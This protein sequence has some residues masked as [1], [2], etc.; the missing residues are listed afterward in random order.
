MP[1]DEDRRRKLVRI[2]KRAK[3][4]GDTEVYEWAKSEYEKSA[5]DSPAATPAAPPADVPGQAAPAGRGAGRVGTPPKPPI[6][7]PA[8]ANPVTGDLLLDS[9]DPFEGLSGARQGAFEVPPDRAPDLERAVADSK[10]LP[11]FPVRESYDVIRPHE[12]YLDLALVGLGDAIGSMPF[13]GDPAK[14]GSDEWRRA[15]QIP[16]QLIAGIGADPTINAPL[17]GPD[18]SMQE[19]VRGVMESLGEGWKQNVRA[20]LMSI[21][22]GNLDPARHL[23]SRRTLEKQHKADEGDP[24]TLVQEFITDAVGTGGAGLLDDAVKGAVRRGKAAAR[25]PV[26]EALGILD[27]IP[28]SQRMAVDRA[29][30]AAEEAVEHSLK[31]GTDAADEAASAA[32]RRAREAAEAAETSPHIPRWFDDIERQLRPAEKAPPGPSPEARRA[33]LERE[34]ERLERDLGTMPAAERRAA[35]KKSEKIREQLEEL[36]EAL[37]APGSRRVPQSPHYSPFQ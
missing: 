30:R 3:E 32:V 2:G 22:Q 24:T 19:Y 20:G 23:Y 9:S 7:V 28:A 21:A 12:S 18:S 4:A 15:T 36:P 1:G 33:A 14:G 6:P 35:S 13:I 27:R 34:S 17:P 5:G 37:Q 26:G 10:P 16:G 25:R 8:G 31:A 29:R 11:E